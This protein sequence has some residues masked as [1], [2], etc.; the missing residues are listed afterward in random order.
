LPK[1]AW[2]NFTLGN[3][4]QP[5]AAR[6]YRSHFPGRRGEAETE[7][8][9]RILCAMLLTLRG[10]PFL[11]YGEEIGLRGG[12]MRRAEILDPAGISTWPLPFGRDP[13]RRPMPWDSSAN[14]GFSPAKPWLP[15]DDDYRERNVEAQRSDPASLFNIYARL[16]RL[17]RSEKALEEG[18]IRFLET[19]RRVLA[20]QRSAGTDRIS[21]YLNFSRLRKRVRLDQASEVLFGSHRK[22]GEAIASGI[23]ILSGYEVLVTEVP[24][25]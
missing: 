8:R 21:V 24:A 22:A 13:E 18:D 16:I 19:P 4:D 7:A 6:R 15:L 23:V 3:H 25:R 1:G 10:T 17:R 9:C 20:Y 11:Y 5:R 14:A 12:R 2:P